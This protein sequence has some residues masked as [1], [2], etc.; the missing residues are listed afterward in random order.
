MVLYGVSEH[1][2]VVV[3]EDSL[4]GDI[5]IMQDRPDL[6]RR[7]RALHRLAAHLPSLRPRADGNYTLPQKGQK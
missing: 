5:K 1:S 3:L 2:C 6:Y 7:A 4:L